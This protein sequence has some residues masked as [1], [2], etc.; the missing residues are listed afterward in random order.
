MILDPLTATVLLAA[1]LFCGFVNALVSS[2]S[3]VSLPVLIFLG[4]PSTVA[5]G[6]NRLAILAG[7]L[8]SLVAFQRRGAV[9][10]RRSL[11]LCIPCVAGSVLG[12]WLASVLDA[13]QVGWVVV[14]VLVVALATVTLTQR[15]APPA[16]SEEGQTLRIRGRHDLLFVAIGGWAGFIGAHS[17]IAIL[18]A[19]VLGLGFNIIQANA[20]KAL[21]LVAVGLSSI[22][23]FGA[24]AEVNW[25]YGVCMSVGG[26]AGGWAGGC[27]A[28]Y[29]RINKWMPRLLVVTVL[30]E[31]V[32][33][34]AAMVVR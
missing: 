16:Q 13:N 21:L 2:G 23:V 27:L 29:G 6:T 7:A 28:T 34:V 4:L 17:A 33:L 5:N 3:A 8:S 25:G 22:A 9:D 1:G 19:L 10:W 30:A 11:R 14:I 18:L 24:T 32:Q 31:L 12:A 15:L 26:V 20:A